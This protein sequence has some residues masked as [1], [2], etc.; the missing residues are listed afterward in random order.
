MPSQSANVS[1]GNVTTFLLD[2]KLVLEENNR[3]I[4]ELEAISEKQHFEIV[5]LTNALKEAEEVSKTS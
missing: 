4:V 3:Q 5:R 1:G 2:E